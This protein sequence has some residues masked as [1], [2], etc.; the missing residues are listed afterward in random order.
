MFI[1]VVPFQNG[2][3]IPPKYT[4]EGSDISPAIEWGDLPEGT[5]SLV[6]IMDDPDAPVGTFTHWIIYDIPASMKSLPENV[7]LTPEWNACKQGRNDF[8]Q[9]G[10]G[11]PCPPRGHGK[12][13]YFFKLYALDIETLGLPASAS[14]HDVESKM[15]G[16]VLAQAQY[17]GTYERR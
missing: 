17:S 9:V 16:H 13:R 3:P 5:Q 10:Y 6:L 7:P 14:R 4:C 11:G 2:N 15:K 8:R 1:R 12:H